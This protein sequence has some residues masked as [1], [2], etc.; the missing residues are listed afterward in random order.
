MFIIQS[1][2]IQ[3]FTLWYPI[4][5]WYPIT[6]FKVLVPNNSKCWYPV[7]K[8]W[9]YIYTLCINFLVLCHT[10]RNVVICKPVAFL[11]FWS[12]Q[13]NQRANTVL[14]WFWHAEINGHGQVHHDC[15]TRLDVSRKEYNY[16]YQIAQCHD[17]CHT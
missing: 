9:I 14:K 1:A 15:E 17:T 4:M 6:I 16:T 7:I 2:G 5:F 8:L 11:N 13:D 12:K 3:L 10:R